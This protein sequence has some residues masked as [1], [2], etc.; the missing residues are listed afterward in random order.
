M[1]QFNNLSTRTK[2]ILDF[3]IMWILMM[4]VIIIAYVTISGMAQSEKTFHNVHFEIS[5]QLTALR[6]NLN[7]S[8]ADMLQMM[9]VTD[10]KQWITLKQEMAQRSQQ[11]DTAIAKLLTLNPD[12]VFQSKLQNLKNE[13]TDYQRKWEQGTDLIFAGKVEEA[14]Q[15]GLTVADAVYERARALTLEMNEVATNALDIRLAQDQKAAQSST[16]LFMVVGVIALFLGAGLVFSLI[17]TIAGPLNNISKSAKQIATGDLTVSVPTDQRTDEVGALAHAFRQMVEYLRSATADIS[18]AVSQLGTSSGEI[19]AATT[20]IASGTSETATAIS[21]TTTTVEQV[22][23]AVQLSTQKAKYVS[24]SAQRVSQVSQT[25]QKAVEETIAGMRHIRDQMESIAQTIV[26]LSEQSQSIG[27]IIASVTDIADQSNLLAVNAAIEAAKAGEQGRGFAVVAQEIKSLAE[28][29]KQSTAQVRGI[30]NDIQKAT[31]AAV[32]ATEQGSK[33]V[34]AGV[35][36]S[37][38]AGEA[39]RV[40]A[41]SSGAAVQAA[42]Q[43]VSSS[44]EQVVGMDQIGLA[45]KNINQAGAETAASMRQVEVSAQNLHELGQKLQELVQRFKR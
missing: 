13:L 12:P 27:G 45:M 31:S 32:M 25:G 44:Q 11:D 14:R 7:N 5:L 1:H 10:R 42:I 36:Q 21:E 20:Q 28:Q 26:R 35:K 40:L 24:D 19:L 18:L 33:A 4:A 2:L 17:Q 8:R 39:I 34:E 29:S 22:R 16:F 15:M 23:Q 3:A 9:L 37:A 6:S 30:L 43:I 41:E 38:Q